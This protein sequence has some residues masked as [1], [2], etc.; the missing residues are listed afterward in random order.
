[1]ATHSSVLAWRIP[2]TENSPQRNRESDTAEA[3][4]HNAHTHHLPAET[5]LHQLPFLLFCISVDKISSPQDLFVSICYCF[6]LSFIQMTLKQKSESEVAQ[7][8]PALCDPMDCSLP[9]FSVHGIFQARLLEWG[10]ISFPRG[11]FQP[12]DQAKGLPHCRLVFYHLSHQGSLILQK[13]NI[14]SFRQPQYI[15]PDIVLNYFHKILLIPST[16]L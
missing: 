1:M 13:F 8:C 9:H 5:C 11:S 2:W 7:S 16:I 6:V 12:R 3:V 14:Y 4:Q 15:Y 10:A